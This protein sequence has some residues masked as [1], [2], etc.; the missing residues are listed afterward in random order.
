MH[1]FAYFRK[2]ESPLAI[3][4]RDVLASTNNTC[5]YRRLL[6]LFVEKTR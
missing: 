3:F 5:L 2:E 4:L 6:C 1:I